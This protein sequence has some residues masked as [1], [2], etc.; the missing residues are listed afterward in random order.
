MSFL[1]GDY[2]GF[3]YGGIH[4]SSIGISRVFNSNRYSE[5]IC[6]N[7]KDTTFQIPGRAGSLY[8]DKTIN[9]KTFNFQIAY[10]NLTISQK[11]KIESLYSKEEPQDLIL[12]ETPYKI[13]KAVSTGDSKFNF[14][15]FDVPE[16]DEISLENPK[17]K[18]ILVN[19]NTF[20]EK[21]EFVTDFY[22]FKYQDVWKLN[23]NIVSLID[24]GITYTNEPTNGDYFIIKYLGKIIFKGEGTI[25]LICYDVYARERYRYLEDYTEINI[26]EW[27]SNFNNLDEW[28]GICGLKNT[29]GEIDKLYY[30]TNSISVYN[31]GDIKIGINLYILGE[32]ISENEYKY[33]LK[34]SQY[35]NS[36][37]LL[38]NGITAYPYLKIDT[39]NNLMISCSLQNNNF[40]EA[41]QDGLYY[42]DAN[43]QFKLRTDNTSYDV[44]YN[45]NI[46]SL[47]ESEVDDVYNGG[48]YFKLDPKKL[49][50]LLIQS[51]SDNLLQ[52]KI[53]AIKYN[54][55]YY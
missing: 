21:V 51:N 43:N 32:Y 4:S 9:P 38:I 41:G 54:Y 52:G 50:T 17:N 23:G 40:I 42:K 49:D 39:K 2:I 6:P 24:Y 53:V 26:N 11:N 16:S 33:N 55:L 28:K 35:N 7:S 47:Y 15:P 18:N 1:K 29:Q 22:T 34:I 31:A 45:L 8:S 20:K 3:T 19:F 37:S 44:T 46:S 27:D 10:D 12:D 48:R 13:Y 36:S 14:I 25:N 5:S 30:N